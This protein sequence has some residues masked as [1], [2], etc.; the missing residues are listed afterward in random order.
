MRKNNNEED[1]DVK[2]VRLD[3]KTAEKLWNSENA[4]IKKLILSAGYSEKDFNQKPI[5]FNDIDKPRGYIFSDKG[6]YRAVRWK[7]QDES[8]C[9]SPLFR[10]I[11]D[12]ETALAISMLGWLMKEYNQGWEPNWLDTEEI[13]YCIVRKFFDKTGKNNFIVREA[14]YEYCYLTFKT[15]RIAEKFLMDQEDLILQYFGV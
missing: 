13:K 5:Q 14:K 4:D 10:T 2:T 3:F 8:Y 12:C 15:K 1:E 6:D 11:T 7:R 9:L